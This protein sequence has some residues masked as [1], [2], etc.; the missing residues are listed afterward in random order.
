MESGGAQGW[1][2]R[3]Y[4]GALGPRRSQEGFTEFAFG[5][6]GAQNSPGWK[7]GVL[8]GVQGGPGGSKE[9]LV[10]DI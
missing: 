1:T 8:R 9:D 3:L 6:K 2:E 7:Q 10:M 4:L 5:G